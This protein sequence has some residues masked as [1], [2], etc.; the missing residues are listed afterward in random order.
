[1]H[2]NITR[3]LLATVLTASAV[4]GMAAP[5]S[6]TETPAKIPSSLIGADQAALWTPSMWAQQLDD[7]D[8]AGIDE[9]I[10]NYAVKKTDAGLQAY[11][12]S[13]VPGT[14]P[15]PHAK[16][17]ESVVDELLEGARARGMKVWLGTYL[18]DQDWFDEPVVADDI[19]ANGVI[20]TQVLEDLDKRYA[21]YSDVVEGWYLSTEVFSSYS[22]VWDAHVALVDYY[23]GLTDVAS[24]AAT[25]TRTMVSPFFN[26]REDSD[27]KQL[28]IDLWTSMWTRILDA[29]PLDVIAL[30]DG[31]GDCWQN[32]CGPWAGNPSAIK[33]ALMTKYTATQAAIDAAGR[34]TELWANMDLYDSY[35]YSQPIGDI[36]DFHT[37]LTPLVSHF[38]SWSFSRQYAP[39][40]LGVD[41]FSKPFGIWNQGGEL[42]QVPPSA[43]VNVVATQSGDVETVTW[44]ASIPAEGA[45]I[46]HYRVNDASGT[47][48]GQEWDG[49]W[50]GKG[51]CVTLQAVDTSG[52]VSEV[53]PTC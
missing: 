23:K 5:A 6:A 1:M 20:T 25:A 32:E 41:S 40:T 43:P 16:G 51:E 26:I 38:T 12:P 15:V 37:A 46:A 2:R 31:T 50:S 42:S 11:Y 33:S 19:P 3:L 13:S 39:W 4:V 52:N 8:A 7:L 29:A 21:G 10:L 9:V 36:Q 48:I 53:V 45:R 30:Q 28:R 24:T 49:S 35:G 27:R 18:P 17:S 14:K 22:W 47:Q 44:D 34:D